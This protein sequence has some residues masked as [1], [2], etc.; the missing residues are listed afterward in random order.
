MQEN[1][2][3]CL[4]ITGETMYEKNGWHGRNAVRQQ[5]WMTLESITNK[6]NLICKSYRG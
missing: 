4:D 6:Y 1:K 5:S 2:K 3:E